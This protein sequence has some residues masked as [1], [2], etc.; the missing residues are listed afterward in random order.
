MNL[1]SRYLLALRYE[2][3]EDPF[4]ALQ[5]ESGTITAVP[6]ASLGD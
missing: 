6:G 1:P 3:V 2:Y 5:H 4:K